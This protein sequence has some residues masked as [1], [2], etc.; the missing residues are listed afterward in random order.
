MTKR[1]QMC[2]ALSVV[3]LFYTGVFQCN[4]SLLLR[5]FYLF[6]FLLTSAVVFLN[7]S[8]VNTSFVSFLAPSLW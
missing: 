6:L 3:Y 2:I 5:Q 8:F 7:I 4:I 1:V